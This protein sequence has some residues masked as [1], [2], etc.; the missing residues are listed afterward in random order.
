MDK[1]NDEEKKSFVF[2]SFMDEFLCVCVFGCRA[3]DVAGIKCC[4]EKTTWFSSMFS[5]M[6]ELYAIDQSRF[7]THV[8]PLA[9]SQL[10]FFF[11]LNKK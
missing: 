11:F 1:C 8:S 10:F 4:S 2:F 9:V 5:L 6:Q 3:L 7:D